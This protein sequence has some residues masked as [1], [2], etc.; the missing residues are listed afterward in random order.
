MRTATL[1]WTAVAALC[2]AGTPAVAQKDDRQSQQQ[3][4]RK[5]LQ[6]D[7]QEVRT[8][9][10]EEWLLVTG[11]VK[12]STPDGFVLEYGGG[13]ITVEMDDYDNYEENVLLPDDRVTV[14]GR[15]DD[16]LFERRAIEAVSVYVDRLHTAFFASAADEEGGFIS[17]LSPDYLSDGEL[18]ALTGRVSSR[19]GDMLTLRTGLREVKVDTTG[20]DRELKV[21]SG[22]R[23]T[24]Y[25]E[26]DRDL[27][28]R[29]EVQAHSVVRLS[30]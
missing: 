7:R 17:Y 21:G 5:A 11:K 13:Q 22:D 12:S 2:L 1:V 20:I 30:G 8:A 29:N 15:M 14:T 4:E 23:V 24:V 25:G 6:S 27:F 16:D 26:F 28:E 9:A 19:E 10:D 3:G 18:V